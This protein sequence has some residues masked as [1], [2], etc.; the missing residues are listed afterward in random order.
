MIYTIIGVFVCVCVCDQTRT[1]LLY[2]DNIYS[3]KYIPTADGDLEVCA[4]IFV[5]YLPIF[6]AIYEY[7]IELH[8]NALNMCVWLSNKIQQVLV[9]LSGKFTIRPHTDAQTSRRRAIRSPF[10]IS[11]TDRLTDTAAV[12]EKCLFK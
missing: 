4:G 1:P 11:N 3:I 7:F 5:A 6:T 10:R 2:N 12:A 9:S 8:K